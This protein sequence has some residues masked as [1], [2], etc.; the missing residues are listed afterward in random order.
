MN[1][2][3][4]VVLDCDEA[5][6]PRVRYTLDTLFM[7]AGIEVIYQEFPPDD[8]PWLFYGRPQLLER[9]EDRCCALVHSPEAWQRL[10]AAQ[11]TVAD[12]YR[13]NGLH[14]PAGS[15]SV[16][17]AERFD[18]SFD[19]LVNAFFFL[20]SCSERGQVAAGVRR[21]LYADSVFA[22][23]GIPLNIVDQYLELLLNKLSECF[24]RTGAPAWPKPK[25]PG[26]G[27]FAV[28][29][30][31]DV[32]FL[33]ENAADMAVQFAKTFL[34]HMV[35]EKS[36]AD[37]VRALRGS[38][39]AL[40]QW[41]DPYGCLQQI[42][43][44][45]VEMN[46]RASF[47]VAVA[48]R[49]AL[50]VNYDIDN[51]RTRARV[52]AVRAAGFDLCLH[53]SY[54]STESGAWYE[55]EAAALARRFGAVRGSR[56]HYLSFDY[57]VL[58]SAQERSGIE[59]DMSMGFPDRVGSRVGFSYPYFPFNLEEDRPYDVVQLCLLLMDVTLRG[60][61]RQG[62]DEAWETIEQQ[63]EGLEKTGGCG[64]VVW[65]PIVFG[66]ARD[67]GYGELFWRMVRH[68]QERGGLATDGASINNYWRSRAASYASLAPVVG[69]S[70]DRIGAHGRSGQEKD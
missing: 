20:A 29:L 63:L 44:R 54:R 7:A 52:Q 45:E 68:V 15:E 24:I 27:A 41:R 35:R 16:L 56:Q 2:P 17:A 49:H 36:P 48:R 18:M 42:I 57:D 69:R 65:H 60:Y 6:V 23:C 62:R 53:G 47:Q 58:F 8:G 25:W 32:D 51:K 28:A 43:Q 30:S 40:L 64:S 55:E 39:S 38:A 31:H 11:S 14:L 37:A 70:G 19:V 61:M 33:P 22:K 1:F 34:R 10:A 13:L 67:P 50:D 59:Y 66:G 9:K 26:G 5:I 46:V 12:D 21:H 4:C 3:L